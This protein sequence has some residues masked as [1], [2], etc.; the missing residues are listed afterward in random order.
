MGERGEKELT[1]VKHRIAAVA[2]ATFALAVLDIRTA[3]ASAEFIAGAREAVLT[4][5]SAQTR[6]VRRA[7]TRIE[8]Y[9]RYRYLPPSAKR[10]CISW[11]EPEWRLSGTVIVPR[12]RCWWVRGVARH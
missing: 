5:L 3:A 12:L 7:R 9:Q 6:R 2:V 4:E 11:L 10:D 1:M 8:V